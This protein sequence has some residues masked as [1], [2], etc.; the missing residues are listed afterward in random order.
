MEIKRYTNNLSPACPADGN[1]ASHLETA[2]IRQLWTFVSFEDMNDDQ[3]IAVDNIEFYATC[4][5]QDTV[6]II[7]APEVNAVAQPTLPGSSRVQRDD[8][9][10]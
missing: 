3:V 1:T 6:N 2:V 10:P 4:Y 7:V 8:S 5:Q 9:L